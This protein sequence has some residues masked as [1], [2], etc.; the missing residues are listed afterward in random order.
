MKWFALPHRVGLAGMLAG[1]A[2]LGGGL[3]TAAIATL[4]A[5]GAATAQ[6]PAAA[7][8]E[9]NVNAAGRIRVALPGG[10][11]NVGN[12]P[13][14]SAGQLQVAPPGVSPAHLPQACG[15][16]LGASP[17]TLLSVGGPGVFRGIVLWTNGPVVTV[18]ISVDG[19]SWMSSTG[20]LNTG[21][22]DNTAGGS[23]GNSIIG[24]PPG[25]S[26]FHFFPPS[27]LGFAHS[28]AITATSPNG[29]AAFCSQ[30]WYTTTS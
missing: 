16:G 12:L 25:S 17:A 27:G 9:Q 30:L 19:Q 11:V 2:L 4:P 7:V 22:A 29:P 8:R 28:L 20:G 21:I 6:L 5:A 23:V 14:N 1:T 10:S 26:N 18:N 3:G 13:V 15:N 24:G